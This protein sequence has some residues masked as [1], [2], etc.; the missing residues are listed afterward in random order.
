VLFIGVSTAESRPRWYTAVAFLKSP[1]STV[2]VE[3]LRTPFVEY[4]FVVQ[5]T[6]VIKEAGMGEADAHSGNGPGGG[7]KWTKEWIERA[8]AAIGDVENN[9]LPLH[10]LVKFAVHLP[11]KSNDSNNA[12]CGSR[13]V[14][15]ITQRAEVAVDG[16][17]TICN[18]PSAVVGLAQEASG[19]EH[20]QTMCRVEAGLGSVKKSTDSNSDGDSASPRVQHYASLQEA[21][22]EETAHAKRAIK[23][24]LMQIRT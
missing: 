7:P 8:K 1:G 10:F 24:G 21:V 3:T 16:R 9:E 12:G 22:F 11:L 14:Y 5:V 15:V 23:G 6:E 13:S 20:T 2:P 19:G 17:I 4:D 18:G